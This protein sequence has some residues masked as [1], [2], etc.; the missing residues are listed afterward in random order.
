MIPGIDVGVNYEPADVAQ[1]LGGDW[2]DVLEL[3][4]KLVYL[5]VGDVVGHGLPAVEDMAQLRSAGRALALQGLP[6]AQLL[7]ELNTF[8]RRASHGQFATMSIDKQLA[9]QKAVVRLSLQLG[10]VVLSSQSGKR[11]HREIQWLTPGSKTVI[12]D[13]KPRPIIVRA[14][15]RQEVGECR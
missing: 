13:G 1:G 14:G 12:V 6:P 3:R 4:R 5:A 2:Y 7:A 9:V 11:C 15:E 8:T 10:Q